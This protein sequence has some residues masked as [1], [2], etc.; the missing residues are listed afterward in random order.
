MNDHRQNLW[1]SVIDHAVRD[2]TGPTDSILRQQA[3]LW[4]TLQ[5]ADRSEVS[6]LAGFE[7]DYLDRGINALA[8]NGWPRRVFARH[9]R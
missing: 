9:L 8:E 6:Q 7:V 3:R 2:A 4:L 1:V 5:S